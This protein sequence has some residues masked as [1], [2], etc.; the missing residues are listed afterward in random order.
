[1]Q[2]VEATTADPSATITVLAH[3]LRSPLQTISLCCDLLADLQHPDDPTAAALLDVIRDTVVQIAGIVDDVQHPGFTGTTTEGAPE[4]PLSEALKEAVDRH[5]AM[6]RVNEVELE[7]VPCE[8]APVTRRSAVAIE[9]SRL[10]RAL[11]NLV[12]NAVQ[13]TPPGGRVSVSAHTLG[14]EVWIFVTD[15]GV[16]IPAERL[17]RLFDTGPHDPH[18]GHGLGLRIVK[19]IVDEAGGRITVASTVGGGTTFTLILPR[20]GRV[21]LQSGQRPRPARPHGGR[22]AVLCR[23]R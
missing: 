12:T 7:L 23:T 10:L 13:H 6:G 8:D 4:T 14:T 16:G 11:A 18:A 21:A 19:R 2:S 5:R 3:D 15:T 9:K 17:E 22:K 20:A 1:M